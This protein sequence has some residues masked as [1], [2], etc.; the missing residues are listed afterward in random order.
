VYTGSRRGQRISRYCTCST[1]GGGGDPGETNITAPLGQGI[2][3]TCML[4]ATAPARL[5]YYNSW[6]GVVDK[7]RSA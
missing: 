5:C 6:G 1:K 2:E 3:E 7:L 4:R